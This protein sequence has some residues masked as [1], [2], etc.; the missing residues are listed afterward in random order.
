M[1][2]LPVLGRFVQLME[3]R[4]VV[5]QPLVQ[6]SKL[7]LNGNDAYCGKAP[8]PLTFITVAGVQ[9]VSLVLLQALKN[10]NL[11]GAIMGKVVYE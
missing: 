3:G 8:P 5:E 9:V 4:S 7:S 6:L 11:I 1:L 10:R 2:A